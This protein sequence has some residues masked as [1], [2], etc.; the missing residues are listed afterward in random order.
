MA[1]KDKLLFPAME[2][3]VATLSR[4]DIRQEVVIL[5][6]PSHD[7]KNIELKDQDF[8]ATGALE[9]FAD[10]YRGATAFK[11]F[12]GIYKTDEG[13][14]LIDQP[15]LIESYAVVDDIKDEQKLSELRGFS[16]HMGRE[17]NQDCVMLVIGHVRFYVEDFRAA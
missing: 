10:L 15:I 16:L 4:D 2:E 3:I 12:K 9:L 8:W 5:V 6:I 1:K 14:Y 11:T 7:K 13:D 17:A